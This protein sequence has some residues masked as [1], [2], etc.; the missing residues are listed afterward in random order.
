MNWISVGLAASSGA[1]A[2]GIA[3]LIV[4]NPKEKRGA[5]AIVFVVCFASLQGLSREFVFPDLNA[6]NQARKVEAALLEVP[7]FQAIKQYDPKTYESLVSDLKGS[8]TK[9]ID[10]SQVIGVVRGHIA[11]LVQKR[12][13]SASD[14]AVVSYMSVMVTEIGELSSRGGDLC[15]RFLFPQPSGP[16]DAR[17]Y[18]SKQTQD[19]DL[20]ALAQVVR[21]SAEHPQT[22]P[23]E[24]DVM[25]ALEPIVVELAKEYGNDIEM[26]QN[27]TAPTV[28]KTKVC[29]MTVDLYSRVLKLPKNESSRVLRFMLSQT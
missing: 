26:L 1:L 24:G 11:G 23:K 5:Y 16:I 18:F 4:R 19:A 29:S 17:K 8:F 21:T 3:S 6:W 2:V 10:D 22:I 7:V 9:G 15:Y 14:D 12:L 13:P 27:P 25:P 28:N 20:A